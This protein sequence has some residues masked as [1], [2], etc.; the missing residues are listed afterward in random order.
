MKEYKY[1]NLSE[2]MKDVE[3]LISMFNDDINKM[4]ESQINLSNEI[5]ERLDNLIK[6]SDGNNIDELLVA[7]SNTA[8]EI[9]LNKKFIMEN[10]IKSA[11]TLDINVGDIRN[12]QADIKDKFEDEYLKTH[13]TWLSKVFDN[14][15]T[16]PEYRK[17]TV[18]LNQLQSFYQSHKNL[19]GQVKDIFNNVKIENNILEITNSLK[20]F[21]TIQNF[22]E[23]I[24]KPDLILSELSSL[25][26]KINTDTKELI[27]K[28]KEEINKMGDSWKE[29]LF[30]EKDFHLKGSF[31]NSK[32]LNY[33][34]GNN[35]LSD[36][37]SGLD[38]SLKSIKEK[39]YSIKNGDI[40]T[41]KIIQ[42]AILGV[43]VMS[44]TQLSLYTAKSLYANYLSNVSISVTKNTNE[45]LNLPFLKQSKNLINSYSPENVFSQDSI[46]T[47]KIDY[48]LS[49]TL[50]GYNSVV[51][52]VVNNIGKSSEIENIYN[53][54]DFS[55]LIIDLNELENKNPAVN[56]T[57]NSP[58]I[59]Q[60]MKHKISSQEIEII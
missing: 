38:K 48:V 13:K 52:Y 53:N 49:K 41:K 14:R 43:V 15:N 32:Q 46:E 7:L 20:Q 30:K 16:S 33:L 56:L 19:S 42:S 59:T 2:V 17:L 51:N 35:I 55:Q 5:S 8:D 25:N 23:L 37:A 27:D 50:D 22:N 39:V 21:N 47:G 34:N 54:L 58:N 18:R 26:K 36:I 44:S 40:D 4:L 1:N 31:E 11:Q 45:I 6:E 10:I 57:V 3:L 12:N 24:S 29:R 9:E 28:I 60:I